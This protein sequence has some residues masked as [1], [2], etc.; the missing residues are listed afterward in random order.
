MA[1]CF[2]TGC[3]Q[4]CPDRLPL[5]SSDL[6]AIH[7]Y[8]KRLAPFDTF[9]DTSLLFRH[10]LALPSKRFS[11]IFH[12]KFMFVTEFYNLPDGSESFSCKIQG[13]LTT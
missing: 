12:A 7:L 10:A 3:Q 2:A 1:Q 11:Y 6:L 8:F 4:R 9:K 13:T 5:V